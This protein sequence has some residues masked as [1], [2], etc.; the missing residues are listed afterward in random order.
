MIRALQRMIDSLLALIITSTDLSE[1]IREVVG[2]IQTRCHSVDNQAIPIDDIEEC[3][4]CFVLVTRCDNNTFIMSR[5]HPHLVEQIAG[6][7]KAFVEETLFDQRHELLVGELVECI[8]GCCTAV[9]LIEIH[10]CH[11]IGDLRRSVGNKSHETTS[12]VEDRPV[13]RPGPVIG[14]VQGVNEHLNVG[15]TLDLTRLNASHR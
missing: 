11:A 5:E 4:G 2:Q 7:L 12:D 8:D 15:F 13:V 14:E 10:L 3:Q 6:W 9:H 1:V